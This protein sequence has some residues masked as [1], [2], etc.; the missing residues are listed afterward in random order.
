MIVR[1]ASEPT[2]SSS[3]SRRAQGR[4]RAPRGRRPCEAAATRRTYAPPRPAGSSSLRSGKGRAAASRRRS[5][6]RV[7]APAGLTRARRATRGGRRRS[8]S[9]SL[10]RR[11]RPSRSRLFGEV[12]TGHR[13]GVH[14]A[15]VVAQEQPREVVDQRTVLRADVDEHACL[16]GP[17]EHG[18]DALV[19]ELEAGDG[20]EDL[21]AREAGVAHRLEPREDG[22]VDTRDHGV[23]RVVDVR[24]RRGLDKA[25]ARGVRRLGAMSFRFA[26]GRPPAVAAEAMVAT[27]QPL[28]TRAGLR[29]LERGGQRGRCGRSPLR[30]CSA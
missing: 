10:R 22:V 12:G 19:I 25:V 21:D 20:G 28:A 23:E 17:L 5:R 9:A 24:L 14:L 29:M 13:Q 1:S 6:H 30:R 7:P 4:P 3:G 18:E 2:G 15:P 26:Y 27:S 11:S 8:G 16:G